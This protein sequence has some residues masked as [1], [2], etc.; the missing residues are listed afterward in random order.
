MYDDQEFQDPYQEMDNEPLNQQETDDP[1]YSQ[2]QPYQEYQETYAEP[3][4]W[5]NQ[6]EIVSTSQAIN[7]TCTLASISSLLALFLCF[8]DQRSRAVR[9]FAIQSV[10]FGV[11]HLGAFAV[12]WIIDMLLGWVPYLGQWLSLMLTVVMIAV[13]ILFYALRVV[14]MFHAYRGQAHTLPI[15]GESLRRFE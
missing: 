4:R 9:R 14:M 7:L 12:C 10:G 1:M 2:Y 13:S 11:I 5:A 15:F 3:E 8:A 6:P